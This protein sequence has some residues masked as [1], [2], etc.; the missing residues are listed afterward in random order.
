MSAP[1]TSET[2]P[3]RSKK[4]RD[5]TPQ[6]TSLLLPAQSCLACI[7]NSFT[8][9]PYPVD[10]T[11]ASDHASKN[12]PLLAP[13][14]V[15]LASGWLG[16]PLTQS[17]N[18]LGE[19]A[20]ANL[21]RGTSSTTSPASTAPAASSSLVPNS[22]FTCKRR[23]G[24]AI[25]FTTK[26]IMSGKRSGELEG[27]K[28][29]AEGYPR[30]AVLGVLGGGQLGRMLALSCGN[31]G[32]SIKT[33]D[34]SPE[35]C[36]R[37]VSTQVVGHFRHE[38]SVTRFA[39]EVD[40]L[41]VEI[42]HVNVDALRHLQIEVQPPADTI[43][44]IQDKFLQKQFFQSQGGIALGEFAK[45][46]S[47]AELDALVEEFGL[48]LML[49]SRRLAYDG[50]GNFLCK[51]KEDLSVGVQ[52]LGGKD[53][54]AEKFQPFT[55]ELAVIIVRARDGQVVSYPVTETIHRDSI[56]HVTE[57]PAD[58]SQ[59]VA[60]LAEQVAKQTI[61]SFPGSIAGIFAVE[62][63]LVG[64]AVLVNE[65]APRPHNSGHYTMDGSMTSQFENHARAVM[66]WPLGDTSL[67]HPSVIM[68]NLLGEADGL[69]GMAKSHEMMQ[70]ALANKG[71]KVHWYGK[72]DSFAQVK[73]NRKL[74]HINIV[75]SSR[76]GA[77]E[78]LEKIDPSAYAALLKTTPTPIANKSP[79]VS[80]IMGSDS[81]LK[82]M[83]VAALLLE[84]EFN[85]AVEVSIVSAH[86]TPERLV[87]FAKQAHLRGV[88]VII[89]GAG[90]AAH[91]PGMVAAL[92]PL[93]VIG[94]PVLPQG[95]GPSLAGVDA[96]LSICQ[97]P[98]GV[99]VATVAIGNSTNA[100]LLAVRILGVNDPKLLQHM[101]DYQV[102]MKEEVLVK[103]EKFENGGWKDYQFA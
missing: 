29:S 82:T 86:R 76:A 23:R 48:P 11:A 63:F 31:L 78:L 36:A 74:G 18:A 95:H 55:K 28:V 92:T 90:G 17:H 40:V 83:S 56:C 33:L 51:T 59:E 37:V 80:V 79:L 15:P 73:R 99:P 89:A 38:E 75:S 20:V 27:T 72:C 47:Q 2:I 102:R 94:V 91:L 101:A 85:V 21:T 41:T 65:V 6:N 45:F 43:E 97:M 3:F 24:S 49:K 52:A 77:R 71:C 81:D 30:D 62:M 50:R 1:G 69:D 98:R 96:L 35:A 46:D 87:E 8:S 19:D 13:S 54:Y 53:L 100:A 44:I 93:P 34:P 9:C 39:N 25:L 57:T 42:E 7:R 60:A 14:T 103:A 58:V 26:Q 64:S 32:I 88:K 10:S 66:G 16:F 84:K 61:A 5:R 68:L 67:T 12:H 70:V 4:H 22:L